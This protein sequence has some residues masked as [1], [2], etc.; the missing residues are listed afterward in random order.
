MNS[1]VKAVTSLD[2]EK[3]S[4]IISQ[5]P[6]RLNW[7][8][9]S[10]KN[11]LH[12]LCG[13]KV[14]EAGSKTS[15]KILKRL[16]DMGMDIDS[17]HRIQDGKCEFPATP[18]WYAYTKGRNERIYRY[19]L[20]RQAKPDNCWWAIAWYDDVEA[21]ELFLSHGAKLDK[22]LLDNM[23][24]TTI[25]GKQYNFAW[26]ALD[27]GADINSFAPQGVNA[28]MIA[29]RRKDEDLIKKLVSLGVDPDAK[30]TDG[31]SPRSIAEKRGPKRLLK[32]LLDNQ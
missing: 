27:H 13:T 29:V 16:L 3:V 2:A 18:L 4:E 5:Q 17:V 23:F 21:A 26:W 14:D 30:N 25:Y 15:L 20:E 24:V 1:Y 9:R 32:M 10:G 8:E 19:L 12:Y 22:K 7:S 31:E 6:D 11:A 28:L